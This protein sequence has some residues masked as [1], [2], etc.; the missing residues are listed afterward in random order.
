V[1]ACSTSLLPPGPKSDPGCPR[2][3]Q[4]AIP[5]SAIRK[6]IQSGKSNYRNK[7][8]MKILKALAVAAAAMTMLCANSARAAFQFGDFELS[9]A[10]PA[11]P[12]NSW[13]VTWFVSQGGMFDPYLDSITGTI[14]SGTETFEVYFSGPPQQGPG[15][16][17]SQSGWS[18]VVDTALFGQISGPDFAPTLSGPLAFTTSFTGN[19]TAQA[20]TLYFQAYHDGGLR[21][22]SPLLQWNGQLF[23]VVPEPT[24]VIAGALLVLPFGVSTLRILRRKRMA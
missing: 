8:N 12:G 3:G 14:V 7:Q 10:G 6:E 19:P 15:L 2:W 5:S 4:T 21:A 9:Q 24:T 13:S 11:V 22:Q 16:S 20:V 23:T 1:F 17:T 18:T